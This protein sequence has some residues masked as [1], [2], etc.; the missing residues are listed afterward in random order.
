MITFNSLLKGSFGTFL[1][2]IQQIALNPKRHFKQIN[3]I[4]IVVLY[5]TKYISQRRKAKHD[6]REIAP[7]TG[8][9]T[10]LIAIS[11]FC[12]PCQ[13]WRKLDR[14]ESMYNQL[15]TL[16]FHGYGSSANAERHAWRSKAKTGSNKNSYSSKYW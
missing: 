5:L 13:C 16:F 12:L 1:F 15:P 6:E 8:I 4:Y 2:T 9:L 11:T 3:C 10:I 7:S 14:Q